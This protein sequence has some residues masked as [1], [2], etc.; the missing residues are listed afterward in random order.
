MLD[1]IKQ[2]LRAWLT[3]SD[4]PA[5]PT[6]KAGRAVTLTGGSA[7]GPA[8][9]VNRWSQSEAAGHNLG[10]VYAATRAVAGRIAG[11]PVR[12]GRKVRRQAPGK[13]SKAASAAPPWVRAGSVTEL[14]DHP[15]LVALHDPNPYC[16]AFDLLYLL[17]AGLEIFGVSYLWWDADGDGPPRVWVLPAP[18]VREDPDAPVPLSRFVVTPANSAEQ[19]TLTADELLR[20]A[21]PDPANPFDALSPL[22]AAY[23]SVLADEEIRLAQLQT[24]RQGLIGTTVVKVGQHPEAGGLPGAVP[25]LTRDQ[26]RVLQEL[27]RQRY[28]GAEA[29]GLPII[30]DALIQD[31]KRISSTPQEMDFTASAG[32]T[33]EQ[34]LLGF[35]VNGIILGQVEG[36]NRASAT[37]AD[38]HFCF[39]TLGPIV[40]QLGQALTRFLAAVY[41]DPDLLV[42]IDPPKPRDPDSRRADLDQLIRAGAV[43]LNELRAEHGLPPLA[44]GDVPVKQSPSLALAAAADKGAGLI[45]PDPAS[46]W[47]GLPPAELMAALARARG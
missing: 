42:W 7:G 35:G 43:T 29:A 34:I 44:D 24:F 5:P 11:Q 31:V 19:F 15:A 3:A 46:P 14:D 47:V 21:L 39:S 25:T 12:A 2:R 30:L 8:R 1:Y 4:L 27:I 22:R 36:A 9:T 37:V 20:I 6:E 38:E 18:W 26:R 33:R 13:G 17:V 41:D 45:V 16:H 32:L 40:T 23:T 10:W 28:A